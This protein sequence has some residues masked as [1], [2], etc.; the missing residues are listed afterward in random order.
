MVKK[1]DSSYKIELSNFN[2]TVDGCTLDQ[3]PT[4]TP[5]VLNLDDGIDSFGNVEISG[6]FDQN[7]T[8]SKYTFSAMQK[9][10]KDGQ[11]DSRMFSA[12]YDVDNPGGGTTPAPSN[13]FFNATT[14][15]EVTQANSPY[16]IKVQVIENGYV[17]SGKVVQLKPFS[18][19]YGNVSSYTVTTATD[20]YATFNY[21][22]PAT[23]PVNGTSTL[24]QLVN[25][26]NGTIITKDIRLD[27]NSNVVNSF[28]Y[29]LMNE[30]NVSI[31]NAS[32]TEIVS[33]YVVDSQTGVGISGK[34]VSISTLPSGYGGFTASTAVTDASGKAEFTYHAPTD[35]S[36]IDGT[37]RNATLS[38]TENGTT[39]GKVITFNYNM[40]IAISDYN[41]T[42]ETTPIIVNYDNELKNISVVV[43][44]KH[45]IGVEDVNVRISAID[46]VEYGSIISASAI[47][48]DISGHAQF[49]YKAPS[50]VKAVDKN[51]TI[52]NLSIVSNGVL[53]DKNV[54]I[55]FNKV[56]LNISVP[57]V[58][59]S[60]TYKDINLTQNSQ[61]IQMEIQVFEQA[62]NAPY[63]SGNVK[64]SLP[65]SV[66]EGTD[67]GSFDE[68]T[69]AV[70]SN[71]KAVFN[72]TGPQDLQS[73]I[74]NNE[75]N[76][77]FDFSHEDNPTQEDNITVNYSLNGGY[78]PSNYIITTSSSDGKQTMGLQILKS[79]TLYLKDDR[80]I[81]VE[82][83]D[84]KRITI[85][86]KNTLVG[87][88]INSSTGNNEEQLDFNA[89]D[90]VNSKSFS[91]QTYTLSGLLPIEITAEFNDANGNSQTKSII[92][93]IVVLSGPPTA[94]SI[95]YAGVE[96]NSTG[97]KYIE[98]FVVTVT[99]AYSNPVN[100][101]PYIATG[102]MV[103][104][105]V[106]GSS[107]S[108]ERSTKSPRLWH[109]LNDSHG[110][111]NTISGNKAQ[112]E[113]AADVFSYVDFN[114]DKLVVFGSGYV[115]EALGKWDITDSGSANILDLK[116]DYTGSDRT[117][118][119]FAI[120]HNNRQDLC[121]TDGTEY[122]GNM[123]ATNYQLDDN[124][125]AL[126]EFEYDYHLTGKDI[127]VWVNLTGFQADNN[128][129]G[130]IGESKKHTLRG[131]GL[132]TPN[133]YLVKSGSSNNILHFDIH[134]ENAA[135]WYING[136]LGYA[137]TG[138]QVDSVIQSSNS[139]DARSCMNDQVVFVDLNVSN[140]FKD[141]CAITLTNIAVS[142]EFN[143]VTYP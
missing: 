88:L 138:C 25:D 64:V 42:N 117:G 49:T 140:P 27:F 142:S 68:Y 50:D 33:I 18:S 4:Y 37:N 84:I 100:T 139:Y 131:N 16:E 124:G 46:G 115:Y 128:T 105:A 135:E 43:V 99:D 23:L 129:T 17:A 11:V 137:T 59:V 69:V 20:G 116:D 45:G 65:S 112:F 53:V 52:V 106:D 134:H 86:S 47:K 122:V 19:I 126:L 40:S 77:I 28:D 31:A 133:S 83:S 61:N 35:L 14:P 13:G 1:V 10:T 9:T 21:T 95:S 32:Q 127:M 74:D 110:D 102:S 12:V 107:S 91:V 7:C 55:E 51:T 97:A 130:R 94:M 82:D 2:F 26:E 111:L 141:D 8:A 38:F 93:N 44:D 136:H 143:S 39:I 73:L 41:L 125:H 58:V 87:Q 60:N 118:L 54:S 6:T 81:L 36:A 92:M 67:V 75:T 63:T 104:Y 57:I 70:G 132:I 29:N 80:G 3:E 85:R 15:V 5:S 123:K 90:A 48:S 103:E 101:K 71:G 96:Q 78:V 30:H 72:Y 34:T 56:D 24:L 98:K 113:T 121:K 76:A 108:S 114:N 89:S 22:S 109:G 119:F 120:G 79:F 66:I 62:T